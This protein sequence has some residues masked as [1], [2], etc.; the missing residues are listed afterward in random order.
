MNKWL[1]RA[2]AGGLVMTVLTTAGCA[3]KA[4][5]DNSGGAGNTTAAPA[6]QQTKEAAKGDSGAASSG[7]TEEYVFTVHHSGATSHPYQWGSEKFDEVLKEKSGGRMS[8]DIY[9]SNQLAAGSK[10]V[11]ATALGTIDIFIENPMSV[12]NIVPSFEALNMPYLFDTAEQAFA[13]MDH[14]QCRVFAE[15]CEANGIKLLGYWYNG[16]RNIS[17]SKHPINTVDDVKDLKIRIAESQVFSDAFEALGAYPIVLANSEIFT[18]LQM[19]TCDAQENPLNNYINNKYY[20]VNKY[21]SM[22]RHVFSVEPVGMNLELWNSM[23]EEDQKIL[24]EAFDEATV[25]QRQIAQETE[26]KQ[27]SEL[28]ASGAD[29]ELTEIA[30]LTPFKDAVAGVYDKYRATD[31]GKYI[32][33]LETVKGGITK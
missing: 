30:D 13:I 20:E 7:S 1:K 9:P 32:E 17:N 14:E 29:V 33:I 27:L 23:S 15:D 19:K 8:L 24:Q 11:E 6:A 22:T 25:Y 16:W 31:M 3:S 21:L 5:S 4:G 26:E 2:I 12:C 18:A 10:S 28:I